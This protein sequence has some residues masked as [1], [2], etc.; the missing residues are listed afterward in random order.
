LIILLSGLDI[1]G[2]E[3][4]RTVIDL[5][6][7]QAPHLSATVPCEKLAARFGFE[8]TVRGAFPSPR[9]ADPR[10]FV[11]VCGKN[12]KVLRQR[13]K[14]IYM[15]LAPTRPVRAQPTWPFLELL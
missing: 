14:Q 12:K 3:R 4:T 8:P 11:R 2:T 15:M 5:I 13:S 7:N 9:L 1:G 6:D 10:G